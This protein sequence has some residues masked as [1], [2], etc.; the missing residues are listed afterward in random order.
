MENKPKN[1]LVDL[2]FGNTQIII[3]LSVFLLIAGAFSIFTLQREGFPS[4]TLNIAYIT[5]PFPGANADQ[6]ERQLL[7]PI[8]AKIEKID[9]V[10]EYESSASNSFG[11]AVVTF[12]EGIDLDK[13]V[14]DLRAEIDD[15]NLPDGVEDIK[16]SKID[17]TGGL[18]DFVIGVTGIEDPWDLYNQAEEIRKDIKSLGSITDVEILNPLTPKIVIELD[19][20]ALKKKGL[21]RSQVEEVLKTAQIDLPIGS[22]VNRNGDRINL[23]L[24]KEISDLSEL[25]D[26]SLT[27][28][29]KLEDVAHAWVELDN[30]DYYNRLGY[31]VSDDHS[32][33][34]LIER[35]L[36][37]NIKRK[38]SADLLKTDDELAEKIE[39][40]KNENSLGPDF[41]L[42]PIYSMA[43]FTRSQVEEIGSA[44]FGQWLE[45]LGGLGFIG[46]MGG[47]IFLV[48]LLLLVFINARVALLAALSIPLSIIS[49]AIFLKL[50]GIA[51]NTLVLFSM[52]LLLGLVVDP[53]IVFLESIQRY[54]EQGYTGREAAA[55]TVSTVGTGMFLAVLTNVLVF[56]PFGIVSGFFGQII[57]YIPFTVIPAMSASLLIPIVLFTP[58]AAKWLKPRKEINGSGINGQD[59]ELAGTWKFSKLLGR[60]TKNLLA[61]TRGKAILRFVLIMMASILP[62]S[63]AGI[64]TQSGAIKVVQFAESGDAE[65]IAINGEVSDDWSFDKA[66]Y[67]TVVPM[68]SILADQ[69]EIKNFGYYMQN[70]NSFAVI[71]NLYSPDYRQ[72][73]GL[74]TANDLVD[75]LNRDFKSLGENVTITAI[76]D[77]G[78]PPADEYPVSFRFF[79]QDFEKLR[80]AAEEATE[81]LKDQDGVTKVTDTFADSDNVKNGITLLLDEDHDLNINPFLSYATISDQLKENEIAK[82]EL[83]EK[84]YD[85][86]TKLSEPIGSLEDV[87]DIKISLGRGYSV[88]ID[89]LVKDTEEP[90]SQTIKRFNGQRYVEVRAKVD[91]DTDPLKVQQEL[92]DYFD[93]D[94]L[95][96]L[97]LNTEVTE[98]GGIAASIAETFT[99]LFVMLAVALFLIYVLLVIFFRSFLSPL[100]ILFAVPLGFI[101]VFP[102]IAATTGQLGFLELL[103]VVAMAGIVVNVTILIIGFANHLKAQGQDTA[104]AISTSIAV[105]FRPILL[106]QMTAF[107]SLIPLAIYSP[108]WRGLAMVIAFGI[109]VS[110]LLSLITTPI[111]YAWNEAI[112]RFFNRK[113]QTEPTIA[114]EFL[115]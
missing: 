97:G 104:T 32:D 6:V 103:G 81:F 114:P 96:D 113:K 101:G 14:Q 61:P 40:I 79:D 92:K 41:E 37:L 83:G 71:A 19:E 30:N 76:A 88:T 63:I 68:Q 38:D 77:D 44:L 39:E 93:E 49:A 78:G 46:Y 87:E 7:E 34:M 15:I 57:K 23:G 52:I 102:A 16:V 53:T 108:F 35:T 10:A 74:R 20:D 11:M 8:E 75:D 4:V 84:T 54:R 95:G 72:D 60:F 26:I 65:L 85:V 59:P 47:A 107:G 111:L 94:K 73:E 67:S 110:A 69:P 24:K 70:G 9:H 56:V 36:L 50:F 33:E 25:R 22:F 90:K 51:M 45:D 86:V 31:R 18:G 62:F 21:T 12:E 48:L 3:L 5:A 105:R 82:L 80:K 17:I 91:D 89:D 1:K 115:N 42:I 29:V 99:E 112:I 27:P 55:K 98:S 43:D 106:T 64:M 13:H 66:V 2:I 100:I 28:A 58:I 109:V